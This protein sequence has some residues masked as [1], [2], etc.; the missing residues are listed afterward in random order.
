M[1]DLRR[2]CASGLAELG[3]N[4]TTIG[5]VLR[6]KSA[7]AGVLGVYDC[8][9]RKPEMSAMKSTPPETATTVL[10]LGETR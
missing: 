4:R 9:G 1:H 10:R 8:Y 3:V 7:D 2:T 6:H 5:K